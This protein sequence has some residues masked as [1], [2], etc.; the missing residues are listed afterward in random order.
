MYVFLVVTNGKIYKF[1]VKLIN[2]ININLKL[3]QLT[4]ILMSYH[5]LCAPTTF[6]RRYNPEIFNSLS[7]SSEERGNY[8]TYWISQ[9]VTLDKTDSIRTGLF[10]PESE[11]LDDLFEQYGKEW[12]SEVKNDLRN[13][14]SRFNP[15][16]EKV[17]VKVNPL[18]P[19]RKQEAQNFIDAI[20][21]SAQEF[22]GV[23]IE[24]P[25]ELEIR[26]VEGF[27]PSSMGTE[28]KNGKAYIVG[29]TRNFLSE[30]EGYL[31]SLIHESVAHQTVDDS[32]KLLEKIFG[33]YIYDVEEGFAKLFTKKIGEKILNRELRY[34]A[35]GGLQSIAYDTF[36]QNWNSLSGNN[37]SLW[38]EKC[39]EE[40]EKLSRN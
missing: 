38:Y 29:Q 19:S 40:T 34:G 14:E 12:P 35:S 7:V 28:I 32:R 16:F 36:N 21:D 23:I 9:G 1:E 11:F 17:R 39:L 2:M 6:N 26:V 30:G 3:D 20:Y 13:F 22:T 18:I 5:I 10:F 8:L 27:A 25:R 31:I 24:R 4:S 33:K 37:F 15:Y